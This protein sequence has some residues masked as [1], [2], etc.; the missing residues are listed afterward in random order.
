[1]QTAKLCQE[2]NRKTHLIC[3]INE[4]KFTRP[5]HQRTHNNTKNRGFSIYNRFMAS[6]CKR[7]GSAVA[8]SCCAALLLLGQIPIMI[9]SKIDSFISWRICTTV[10]KNQFPKISSRE[11][12]PTTTMDKRTF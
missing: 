8:Y 9:K 4:I 3:G 10:I 11:T 2:K 6:E 1:M 7:N 5:P 12:R